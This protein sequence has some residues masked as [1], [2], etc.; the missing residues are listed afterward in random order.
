MYSIKLDGEYIY[1]HLLN[2]MAIDVT[3]DQELNKSGTLKI[4]LPPNSKEPVPLKSVFELYKDNKKVFEG[5]AIAPSKNLYGIVKYEVLGALDYFNDSVLQPFNFTNKTAGQFLAWIIEQHNSQVDE[6][7]QFKMGKCDVTDGD[8]TENIVRSC[9][10]YSCT[11]DI[12]KSRLIDKLGG[13]LN[14]RYEN[15]GKYI[16]YLTYGENNTQK[17][18]FKKNLIDLTDE[19]NAG[20]IC[21]ILI[22][23]G[24]QEEDKICDITTVNDN[25]NYIKNDES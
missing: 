19:H 1:S 10:S 21:S 8:S 15:D 13:N 7:K 16:D 23:V 2:K 25:K 17:I 11:W 4:S 18:E 3:L 20:D 9:E 5:R 12:I 22:P 6:F 24:H 14:V